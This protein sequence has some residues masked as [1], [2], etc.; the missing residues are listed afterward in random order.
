MWKW[1]EDDSIWVNV[2]GCHDHVILHAALE[3]K[4]PYISV[5]GSS[6]YEVKYVD[7]ELPARRFV[8]DDYR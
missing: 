6:A 2:L 3:T 1:G 4:C 5:R 7:L 8:L